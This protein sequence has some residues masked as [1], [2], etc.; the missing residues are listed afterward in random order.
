MNQAEALGQRLR[1][2]REAKELTLE[3]TEQATRIRARFLEAL[4]SGDYTGMMPVQAQGFLRN[5][6]RFLGLDLDLLLVELEVEK[7]RR[8]RHPPQ[9][10][11]TAEASNG[12]SP[13]QLFITET[14][15]TPVA[16][17][18]TARNRSRRQR[19][20]RT[21]RGWLW[22]IM[23]V[24]LSGAI[25]VAVILGTT[26]L[27]DQLAEDETNSEV[28]TLITPSP[29]DSAS[30]DANTTPGESL[31]TA[32]ETNIAPDETAATS[33][34]DDGSLPAPESTFVP[35]ALTGTEVT[36]DISIVQRTW[37]RITADGTVAYE[38]MAQVGDRLLYTAQQSINVRANNAAGLNLTV[39][40]Q[41]QGI[42]GARGHLFDTTFA[43]EGAPVSQLPSDQA[44]L[45]PT[46][47]A[48]SP[49]DLVAP[50]FTT[51]PTQ[52]AFVFTATPSGPTPTQPLMAG[53][54][55]EDATQIPPVQAVVVTAT[56]TLAPPTASSTPS[57]T[58]TEAP[59]GAPTATSVPSETPTV[60]STPS[61]TPLP[62][63]TPSHTP[64][65]TR[66]PTTTPTAS[67]TPSLTSPPTSTLTNTPSLTPSNT[68]TPTATLTNTPTPTATF[69]PTY[70]N[71][72]F[73]T[74]SPT[75]SFTPTQTPFL[76]PRLTRTP[77]PVPK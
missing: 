25:V 58:P 26:Q 22:N 23:I 27:F 11:T 49:P 20:Q 33:A 64:T 74:W 4:E 31:E 54:G 13:A 36:V 9:Q 12:P 8:R 73:P 34:P 46:L 41:P 71:T 57:E 21:Q 72:P 70:T 66:T 15:I 40:N 10:S 44:A 61:F 63:N 48:T 7:P 50:T 53:P 39:N 1:E 77:S 47:T 30:P 55:G 68:P 24:L 38:G 75:P 32:P 3:Q 45:L 59:T 52:A 69:T 17:P 28:E 62:S 16:E 5:Y 67:Y 65:G 6:A 37:V 42:V 51:S 19:R 35:P 76:P 18:V 14:T 2:V 56:D 29:Q 60:T 43:L